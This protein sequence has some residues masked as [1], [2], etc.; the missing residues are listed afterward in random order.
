MVRVEEEERREQRAGQSVAGRMT[1]GFED[2]TTGCAF[3]EFM[4]KSCHYI[5]VWLALPLAFD[6]LT[7]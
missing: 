5:N 2:L 6:I 7:Q 4:S 3:K 1:A